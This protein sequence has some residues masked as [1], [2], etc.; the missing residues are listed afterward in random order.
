ME[1]GGSARALHAW[2]PAGPPVSESLLTV[3]A[4]CPFSM[5]PLWVCAW[6]RSSIRPLSNPMSQ[7]S[8]VTEAQRGQV[9]SGWQRLASSPTS[10][11][12]THTICEEACWESQGLRK[13][14]SLSTANPEALCFL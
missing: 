12:P 5:S 10:L 13:G 8:I 2:L 1:N 4:V 7:G 14:N 6:P 9:S 11:F 3:V